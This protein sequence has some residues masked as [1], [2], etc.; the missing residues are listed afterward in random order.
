MHPDA[1]AL[2]LRLDDGAEL[3][4]TEQQTADAD[5]RLVYVQHPFPAQGQTTDTTHLIIGE[6]ANGPS[7]E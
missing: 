5:L 4:L 7:W 3:T 2:D 6:R 1:R